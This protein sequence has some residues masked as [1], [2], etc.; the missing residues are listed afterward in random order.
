MVTSSGVCALFLFDSNVFLC[1]CP[2][3]VPSTGF[4]SVRYSPLHPR[5]HHSQ[6]TRVCRY[7]ATPFR[8][9]FA[10]LSGFLVVSLV[11]H[12]IF[13]IEIFKRTRSVQVASCCCVL[14]QPVG[15]LCDFS[16]YVTFRNLSNYSLISIADTVSTALHSRH[17]RPLVKCD[18]SGS[19]ARKNGGLIM[20]K[21][22]SAH[23]TRG[24]Y[25]SGRRKRSHYQPHIRVQSRYI[26][27]GSI[28][29]CSH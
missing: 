6:N 3:F 17:A 1:D 21:R 22:T 10:Q 14:L 9:R 12:R 25:L 8:R 11:L 7:K 4:Y 15:F 23:L 19:S 16:L 26:G 5:H 28:H 18:K 20:S 27:P 24:P 13:V 29:F 2:K